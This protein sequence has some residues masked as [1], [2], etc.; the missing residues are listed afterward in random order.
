MAISREEKA[1]NFR[2]E[3][4]DIRNLNIPTFCDK[5]NGVMVFKGVG[6]YKCEDCGNVEYDDYGKVRN[7]IE[8]HQGATSAQ[9]SMATGVSQ[10]AIRDM[11]KEERLEIAAGSNSFLACEMC[12]AKIRYGRVCRGCEAA[13]HQSLEDKARHTKHNL[14]GFSAELPRMD[15]GA[16]R[17]T[18]TL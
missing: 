7:Y 16:K 3:L 9:V 10:K 11:L 14:A 6:E 5:C 2:R 1:E 4:L 15:E 13:Y 17:F 12:G 8:K 18:R